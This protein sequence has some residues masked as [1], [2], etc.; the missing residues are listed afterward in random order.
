MNYLAYFKQNLLDL[1]TH[2]GNVGQLWAPYSNGCP[3]KNFTYR[4]IQNVNSFS[5]KDMKIEKAEGSNSTTFQVIFSRGGVCEVA[6]K[7]QKYP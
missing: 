7:D 2:I 6:K 1:Q 4:E 5:Q 3:Y